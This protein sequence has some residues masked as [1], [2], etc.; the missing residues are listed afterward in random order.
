MNVMKKMVRKGQRGRH[1]R[2]KVVWIGGRGRGQRNVRKRVD[3]A[4]E[5]RVRRM[6]GFDD[7]R[8]KWVKGPMM[9]FG[10]AP[11]LAFCGALY[12]CF[13]FGFESEEVLH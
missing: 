2:K 5:G 10:S 9:H 4:R 8:G 7:W 3:W 1:E 11:S 12:Q 6:K 13:V